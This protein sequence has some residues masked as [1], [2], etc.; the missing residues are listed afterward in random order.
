M[1]LAATMLDNT[2]LWFQMYSPHLYAIELVN[3]HQMSDTYN[4]I[5]TNRA[6]RVTV[7]APGQYFY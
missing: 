1:R 3:I 6:F 4:T 2:A 7:L 5:R